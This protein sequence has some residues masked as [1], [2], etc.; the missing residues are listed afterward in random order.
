[1]KTYT[2]CSPRT[3]SSTDWAA[4]FRTTTR[5]WRFLTRVAGNTNTL[6]LISGV[7]SSGTLGFYSDCESPAISYFGGEVISVV[8]TYGNDRG[9]GQ[10]MHGFER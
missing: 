8:T 5:A 10:E 3:S 4:S 9:A 6:R 2:G 7:S 1:M